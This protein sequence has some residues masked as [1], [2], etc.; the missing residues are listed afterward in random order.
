VATSAAPLFF[1]GKRRDYEPLPDLPKF[2]IL[3]GD[4]VG[5]FDALIGKYFLQVICNKSSLKPR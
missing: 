1:G 2:H 4:Q 3:E 5:D